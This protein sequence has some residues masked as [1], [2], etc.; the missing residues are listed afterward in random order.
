MI[1]RLLESSYGIMVFKYLT[2][3]RMEVRI[4]CHDCGLASCSDSK[5]RDAAVLKKGRCPAQRKSL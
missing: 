2:E 4:S 1:P 5:G 3:K